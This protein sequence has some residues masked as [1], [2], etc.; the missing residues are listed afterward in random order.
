MSDAG[1]IRAL[2][3]QKAFERSKSRLDSV[4]EQEA[5]TAFA[6]RSFDTVLTA[7]SKSDKIDRVSVLTDDDA[8]ANVA[9]GCGADVIRDPAKGSSVG[10]LVNQTLSAPAGSSTD[11]VLVIMADLPFLTHNDIDAMVA[12]HDGVDVVIAPDRHEVGTNAI[13]MNLPAA[14]PTSFTLTHSRKRHEQDAKEA[15]LIFAS[16]SS[17]GLSCD[18]DTDAD[19]R[20]LSPYVIAR[21]SNL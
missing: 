7:L 5:R 16:Y 13:L 8:V 2:V 14:M 12:A 4:L 6:K 1:T 20:E 10:A 19:W 17:K 11:R 18:V 3:P 15:G 21:V 9:R